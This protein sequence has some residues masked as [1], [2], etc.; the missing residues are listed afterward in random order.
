M[1][2]RSVKGLMENDNEEGFIGMNNRGKISVFEIVLL[3]V[4]IFA[5]GWMFGSEF[6]VVSAETRQLVND[7]LVEVSLQSDGSWVDKVGRVYH[8]NENGYLELGR[9][10]YSSSATATQ[11]PAGTPTGVAAVGASLA[12]SEGNTG[13]AAGSGSEGLAALAAPMGQLGGLLQGPL[14]TALIWG[15]VVFGGAMAVTSVLG[16]KQELVEAVA[17]AAGI[18]A[19]TAKIA[20]GYFGT[21]TFTSILIGAGVGFA[22]FMLIYKETKYETVTFNC[23]PWQSPVGVSKSICETCNEEGR[24]CSEYRCKSLGQTCELVNEGKVDEMCVNVNPKDV[25]PPVISP[26][27]KELTI[28]YKY[29]PLTSSIPGPGINIVRMNGEN[30]CVE[31]FTPLRFGITVNEP[32]QCKIDFNSTMSFNSMY[33][34]MGGSNSFKYEHYEQFVLPNA[35]DFGNTSYQLRNGKDLSFFIRCQDR[36]GNTNE[37]EY[38][39]NFCVDPSP[40]TTAPRVMLTSQEK[41]GCIPATTDSAVVEFYTNEPAQCRWSRFDQTYDLMEHSMVCADKI[42]QMNAL[43]LYTCSA[44]LTGVTKELTDFYVRCQDL[45]HKPINDRNTNQESF[46]FSLRGSNM[47]KMRNMEPNGTI[48]GGINPM[49]VELKVETLFGCEKGKA[50]CYFSS[51]GIDGDYILFATTNTEDGIHNQTLYLSGGEHEYFIKCVDSGGNLLLNS[52]KFKLNIDTSSPII[53]RIYNDDD[54]LKI[55]TLRE[56]ECSYSYENC[57]FLFEEGAMMPKDNSEIHFAE[58]NNEKTYYIKCRDKYRDLTADCAAIV[59]PT[60]LFYE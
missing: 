60:K 26:D 50:N 5:F 42:F 47:L 28:G 14:G 56:S 15:G 29:V 9:K 38:A 41:E 6:V 3:V 57:D 52:T 34:F 33:S 10:V 37:A 2:K 59:K 31:A 40:D 17:I 21:G 54:Q 48:E 35:E 39:I 16:G 19:F 45:Q 12:A 22:I 13:A 43:Q 7:E 18:G 32:A 53:A 36:N 46:G 27:D 25:S 1:N 24:P 51:N 49:P 11:I 20:Q 55:V 8:E 30:Q 58:W 23:M 44:N 4:S